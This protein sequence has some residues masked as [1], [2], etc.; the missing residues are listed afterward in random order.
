MNSAATVD[1]G[2]ARVK[3]ALSITGIGALYRHA[4]AAAANGEAD[5]ATAILA[6]QRIIRY[7]SS[8]VRGSKSPP[9]YLPTASR[10]GRFSLQT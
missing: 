4:Y 1:P 3:L 10:N 5:N 7:S 8:S 9:K 6:P 2:T